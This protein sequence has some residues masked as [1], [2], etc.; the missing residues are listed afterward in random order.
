MP[1]RVLDEHGRGRA[2]EIAKGIRFAV[3]HG[4][5]VINMSFNFGCGRRGARGRRSA[6]PGLPARRRHG[7]LGRQPRLGGL[8]LPARHRPAR[9]RRRRQHR[10]RLPRRL[11]ADR[12][13]RRR[14]RP[15][16]RHAGARLPLDLR[17]LDLPGDA[18]RPAAPAASASPSNYVGTSMAAAHVSG[19]AAMVLASGTVDRKAKKPGRVGS[20]DEAPARRPPATSGQPATRQG[21][22]LIDA[23]AATLSP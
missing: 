3:A 15:R 16:R 17:R 23:G 6:A 20:G 4:A 19:V 18:E 2:D 9:D 12:P 11:L 22:G 21:A 14:D 1:V 13:R 5:D 7:G 10:G 8:R